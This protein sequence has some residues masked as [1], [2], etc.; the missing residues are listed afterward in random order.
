MTIVQI[1]EEAEM[2]CRDLE[3]TI[4]AFKRMTGCD[5]NIFSNDSELSVSVELPIK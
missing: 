3:K 5:L 1:K 4:L 2:I